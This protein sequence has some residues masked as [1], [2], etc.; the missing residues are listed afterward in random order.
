M[1]GAA[2]CLRLVAVLALAACTG[3][4]TP[5]A[6]APED[7]PTLPGLGAALTPGPVAQANRDI[8]R[9]FVRLVFQRESGVTLKGLLRFE[10][11]VRVALSG[12]GLAA[13]ETELDTLIARLQREAG[14]DI[15]R[16]A[17]AADANILIAT[18]PRARLDEVFPGAEC[19]VSP[20]K[21]SW[22][23][24]RVELAADRLPGWDELG[25]LTE[26]AIYIP[27]D[28]GPQDVRDCLEEELAQ[29]LGPANDL[30]E[31]AQSVFNDDNVHNRLTRFDMLVLR[32]LY[33]PA[34]RTGM[35]RAEAERT[36]RRV[37]ARLNP[38]GQR[39][40]PRNGLRPAQEWEAILRKLFGSTEPRA[41]QRADLRRALRFAQRLPQ[42]DHRLATTLDLLAALEFDTRPELSEGLLQR[43]LESLERGGT[44]GRLRPATL[45]IYLAATKQKLGKPA[46]ALPLIDAALPVLAAYDAAARIDQALI[47][48]TA[49]LDALGRDAEAAQSAID[50]RAWSAYVRGTR[51]GRLLGLSPR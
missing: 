5:P 6:T 17:R 10:T 14:I 34:L 32:L 36:A 19:F 15:A 22:R 3:S 42:P 29:T 9:S 33:D 37:L 7:R 35:P 25:E 48:R 30:F 2:R 21:L 12:A 1:I 11:P 4:V 26:A 24:F 31:L 20:R 27:D 44:A 41:A 49:A 8:A 39:F 46:E 28:A 23:Q 50:S 51:A 16:V 13:Y 45:R 18:A 43:A 38:D 40:A 47:L